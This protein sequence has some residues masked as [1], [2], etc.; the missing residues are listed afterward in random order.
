VSAAASVQRIIVALDGMSAPEALTWL[1]RVPALKNVKVGLE[2]FIEAGPSVV[3]RLRERNLGVLL[4]L[5]LHDIPATMACGC[6]RAAALGVQW[7][8]LH[9]SV[10]THALKAAR[11]GAAEGA[12]EAGRDPPALLA[13]TVL[14]SWNAERFCAE[15]QMAVSLETHVDHLA[16]LA[17]SAGMDGCVCSPQEALRLRTRHPEPFQLVTPG[18]RFSGSEWDDQF[19]VMGPGAAAR[20][21]A[22]LLVIGRPVTRAADPAEALARCVQELERG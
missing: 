16:G 10:G 2:L 12:A 6:R 14:T 4:D 18:I 9:A 19:R 20:A 1:D 7:L 5:K 13:I 22:S 8:T 15:R 11:I 3:A 21:G 17:R